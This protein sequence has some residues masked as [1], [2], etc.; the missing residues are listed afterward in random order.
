MLTPI[1]E[2][3][4]QRLRRMT[5]EQLEVEKQRLRNPSTNN[6]ITLFL[7][8]GQIEIIKA[9]VKERKEISKHI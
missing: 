8:D 5:N 3:H 7:M 6:R 2:Q 4:E 9:I 1:F